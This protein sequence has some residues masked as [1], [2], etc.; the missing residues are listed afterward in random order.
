M[1]VIEKNLI[2]YKI[3]NEIELLSNKKLTNYDEEI[4]GKNGLLDSLNVL[5]IMIFIE[6]EFNIQLNP[7]DITL[8]NFGTVNKIYQ[9]IKD[10]Q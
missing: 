4:F 2:F 3:L 10:S 6:R 1:N 5:H 9:L 8:E 7:E